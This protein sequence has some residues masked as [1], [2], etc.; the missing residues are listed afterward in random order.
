MSIGVT[1]K[2]SSS[3]L[4]DFIQMSSKFSRKE[5][6]VT[7]LVH[8]PNSCRFRI[9]V[10]EIVMCVILVG[11]LNGFHK[12]HYLVVSKRILLRVVPK[13]VLQVLLGH[14]TLL[15]WKSFK[16]MERRSLLR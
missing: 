14:A 10:L 9:V 11:C 7:I 2:V 4:L 3:T 15:R 1:L 5:R 8:Q 13:Y 16:S 6:I 12:V